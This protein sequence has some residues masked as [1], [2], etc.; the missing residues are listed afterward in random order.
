MD[1]K[2][3]QANDLIRNAIVDPEAVS[4]ANQFLLESGTTNLSP[5]TKQ[6]EVE[7][8][9]PQLLVTEAA[10][11]D[12]DGNKNITQNELELIKRFPE[13]HSPLTLMAADYAQRHFSNIT[14]ADD[15]WFG[16][17]DERKDLNRGEIKAWAHKN[18]LKEPNA[19][20]DSVGSRLLE[21]EKYK[22]DLDG[23]NS[24]T[25]KELKSIKDM[26][27]PAS[28][29]HKAAQ[30]ALDNFARISRSDDWIIGGFNP[31]DGYALT[32][33]EIESFIK[34]NGTADRENSD[35][36]PQTYQTERQRVERTLN[37]D[38][39]ADEMVAGAGPAPTSD[40][41][42]GIAGELTKRFLN[43][44]HSALI[45]ATGQEATAM[46]ADAE[47]QDE[48]T[49]DAGDKDT[50]GKE[51]KIDVQLDQ[52]LQRAKEGRSEYNILDASGIERTARI[53][54]E[55]VSKGSSRHYLTLWTVI[56]G[57][58]RPVIRAIENNGAFAQQRNE[59]GSNADW[60]GARW[61]KI[62]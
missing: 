8:V 41:K 53:S 27:D 33:T 1:D 56:D 14:Q 43:Q 28:D 55:P 42:P 48:P 47:N 51:K 50:A 29:V 9:L 40:A 12:V 16:L 15:M 31:F 10:N 5:L 30:F 54:Y 37:Q 62:G 36:E 35:I 17:F 44:L 18:P 34:K 6:L 52:L 61:R 19:L 22:L 46:A 25:R 49:A 13:R 57:V 4:L 11:L 7:G 3:A 32:F 2:V 24:V 20:S 39:G 26:S 45:H 21:Q 58:E 59:D 23:N 38:Q 60:Y